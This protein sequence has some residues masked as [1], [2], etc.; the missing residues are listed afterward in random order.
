MSRYIDAD[1]FYAKV[2]IGEPFIFDHAVE[3]EIK[4]MLGN[5]PTADV[6]PVVH[7]HW[8][9]HKNAEEFYGHLLTKYEC[10]ICHDWSFENSH[11]CPTCG[12]KMD[13]VTE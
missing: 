3:H 7:A 2:V 6:V 5:E 10:S 1:Q 12:A 13:E 8:I 9:K 11:F 4:F